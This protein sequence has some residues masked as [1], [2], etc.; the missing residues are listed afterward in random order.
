MSNF[1]H[2]AQAP[3]QTRPAFPA[4]YGIATSDEGMLPW[5]WAEE[6]LVAARNYWIATTDPGGRAHAA[7]VWGLWL[8][9][10]FVFG[11][12]RE[13]RKGRNLE[14]DPR[15]VVHLESGDEVVILEGVAGTIPLDERLAGAYE[16]KY[17]FRPE[18]AGL[19][20]RVRPRVALAWVE[21]DYPRTATRFAFD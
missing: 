20:L 2:V 14:H 5:T 4:S 12:S 19:W 10:A 21:A 13:S 11:T 6:R 17:A 15:I 16:A 1:G 9:N 3:R 7:P 18:P 8:E